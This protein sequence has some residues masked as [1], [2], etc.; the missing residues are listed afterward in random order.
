LRQVLEGLGC[1]PRLWIAYSGGCD[2]HVLLHACA[3]LRETLPTQVAVIHID[4]GLNP[5]SAH[6]AEHC[7]R[8][9]ADL[10]LAFQQKRAQIR[11]QPGASLEASAKEARYQLLS[12]HLIQGEAVATAHH[13]DDQA[14]T[15]LLA[16]LR[17]SGVHGLAAMP[18]MAPLGQ[19][20]LLRPLLQFDRTAL[21]DYARRHQLRWI[22]DPANQRFEHDRNRIRH[23]VLPLLRE[24]WPAASRTLARS[25]AHCAEAA[26]TVDDWADEQL[27]ALHGRVPGSLSISALTGL[28]RRVARQ[29]VRRWI[30]QQGFRPPSTARL[31]RILSEVIRAR[32]DAMPLVAWHGCEVRRYRDDLF[33]L[34]PLPTS[35]E[36]EL[37][38]VEGVTL[39]LPVGLG[40]LETQT[41][42]SLP[43]PVRVDFTEPGLT[44]R[45][46]DRPGR[47]LRKLLQEAG[48]PSWLRPLVPRLRAADGRLLLVPGLCGCGLP[49]ATVRWQGHPWLGFD[50]FREAPAA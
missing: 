29:L 38:W 26:A 17:G 41:M 8:V 39:N 50:C 5:A 14:E 49:A 12:Q 28:E 33:A 46:P 9:C 35:P 3:S 42:D 13:L 10:G 30:A 11:Q 44:C 22:E 19:G 40:W 1:P 36:G 21:S 16:L 20:L 4:H 6:W 43:F 31:D 37:L 27:D 48:V 23:Q 25:A 45:A 32:A 7:R 15:L 24:R 18:A 34:A 2:S 47:P